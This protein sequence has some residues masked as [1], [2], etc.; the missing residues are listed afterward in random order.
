VGKGGQVYSKGAQRQASIG[1][2]WEEGGV[3]LRSQIGVRKKEK[4]VK[5]SGYLKLQTLTELLIKVRRV[6]RK[7]AGK[8]IPWRVR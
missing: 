5:K 2:N 6:V 7:K 4:S 3:R 1:R 8:S